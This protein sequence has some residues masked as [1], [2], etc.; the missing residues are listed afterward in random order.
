MPNYV[1]KPIGYIK[2]ESLKEKDDHCNKK[3]GETFK[4]QAIINDEL[5]DALEDIETF[6][7]I[8]LIFVFDRNIG[9]GYKTKTPT[10]AEP[11]TER[12]LFVTRTPYRPNPIGISCV[13][14]I[15]RDKNILHFENADI[16]DGTPLLDIKPYIPNSDSRPDSKAGWIDKLGK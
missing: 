6:D 8:W 9:R 7:R 11:S 13:T 2:C 3:K 14:L 15:G 16:L 4:A 10:R 1:M 5:L 12:S